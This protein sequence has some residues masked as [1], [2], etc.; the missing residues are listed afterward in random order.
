[1]NEIFSL[2]LCFIALAVGTYVAG[3]EANVLVLALRVGVLVLVLRVA[4]LIVNNN[5][6]YKPI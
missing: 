3:F 4:V 2:I 5:E 6:M 1:M